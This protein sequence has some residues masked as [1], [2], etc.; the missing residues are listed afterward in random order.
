MKS[1]GAFEDAIVIGV[2]LNDVQHFR[3]G[4]VTTERQQLFPCIL[5]RI[6]VPLKLIA[7]YAVRLGHYRVRN[8]DADASGSRVADDYGR[9]TAEMQSPDINTGIERGADYWLVNAQWPRCSARDSAINRS[10]SDSLMSSVFARSA[11]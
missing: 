6:P 5:K 2:L 4:D 3:W 11:P 9:R 7:Q 8:V 10:M 1:R